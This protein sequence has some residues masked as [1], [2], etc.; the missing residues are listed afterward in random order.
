MAGAHRPRIRKSN[1]AAGAII[2]LDPAAVGPCGLA[3]RLTAGLRYT[4]YETLRAPDFQY[5]G[6][7]FEP[8]MHD[9]LATWIADYVGKDQRV[10]LCVENASYRNTAR[11]LGR[12]IGCIEGL[13]YDLNVAHPADTQYVT[14]NRWRVGVFGLPLPQGREALKAHA[15]AVVSARYSI[16]CGH[17]LAEAILMN[18]WMAVARRPVWADGKLHPAETDRHESKRDHE[19]RA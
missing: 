10:L 5:E 2:T 18:D 3:G 4:R 1:Y 12:A 16:E 17:D 11:H 15:Q 13:L 7:V 14:P 19:I 6:W 8:R 9:D